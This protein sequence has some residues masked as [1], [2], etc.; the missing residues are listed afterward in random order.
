MAEARRIHSQNTINFR[1]VLFVVIIGLIHTSS[2]KSIPHSHK[3][4][5][6]NSYVAGLSLRV[7]NEDSVDSRK[8][9]GIRFYCTR[10]HVL[11]EFNK[12]DFIEYEY[13]TEVEDQEATE[14]KWSEPWFCKRGIAIGIEQDTLSD[15]LRLICSDNSTS[16]TESVAD[17]SELKKCSPAAAVCGLHGRAVPALANGKKAIITLYLS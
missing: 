6:E 14:G 4:C 5:P 12:K 9:S 2:S 10:H 7:H 3:H 16:Q 1:K 15:N 17:W 8:I 13:D 11:S